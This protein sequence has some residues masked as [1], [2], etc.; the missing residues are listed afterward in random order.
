MA[1]LFSRLANLARGSLLSAR[2]PADPAAEALLRAE[3]AEPTRGVAPPPAEPPPPP[4][5]EAPPGPPPRDASGYA[6][7]TL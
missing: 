5:A 6:R 3:L 2:Q 1:G 4:A 7:R